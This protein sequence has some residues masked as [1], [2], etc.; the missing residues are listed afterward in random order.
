MT[1]V[2]PIGIYCY[3]DFDL[4]L[5]SCEVFRTPKLKASINAIQYVRNQPKA[6]FFILV[7]I[8]LQKYYIYSEYTNKFTKNNTYSS[9]TSSKKSIILVR[10]LPS[11]TKEQILINDTYR[12][13]TKAVSARGVVGRLFL[14]ITYIHLISLS[15]TES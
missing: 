7:L 6:F 12:S 15:K 9:T 11:T 13:V 1:S 10:P 4:K 8:P 2:T 14:Y 3:F 5:K